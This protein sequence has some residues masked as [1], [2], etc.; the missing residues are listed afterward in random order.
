M[1]IARF[2]GSKRLHRRRLFPGRYATVVE[3]FAGGGSVT[4]G[5]APRHAFAGEA[6]PATR[7][8]WEVWS[9]PDI[10]EA[11]YGHL[12]ALK[13]AMLDDQ[14]TA[15]PALKARYEEPVEAT[16]SL[17]AVAL[18]MHRLTFGGVTRCNRFGL[19]NVALSR[20]QLGKLAKWRYRFPPAPERLV[21]TPGWEAAIASFAASGAT[22][23]L[24]LVDPPYWMPYTPGTRRRGTGGMTPAYPGHKPHD[25]AT[26]A[27]CLDSAT[28]LAAMPQVERLV[29]TNYLTQEMDEAMHTIANDAG[30][31]I[32]RLDLGRLAGLNRSR[33]AVT[34]ARDTA[35]IM[36]HT[37]DEQLTLWAS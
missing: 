17:A 1:L 34:C 28:A 19:L 23:A 3:A 31:Y 15:W 36:T 27:M 14:A 16:D 18:M 13:Q 25:P 22:N 37:Q 5:L 12:E 21:V 33:A 9:H 29:V 2:P 10:H 4:T 6:N 24:A 20:G 8:V 26:L 30:R 32:Q 7:A 35:W 11:V